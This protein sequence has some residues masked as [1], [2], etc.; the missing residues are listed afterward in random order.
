MALCALAA[1]ATPVERCVSQATESLRA[2]EGELKELEATLARGYAVETEIRT[3]PVFVTCGGYRT[4]VAP[5]PCVRDRVVRSPKR[6]PVDLAEVRRRAS[7]IRERLPA[8]QASA[9]QGA[10]QCRAAYAAAAGAA[11]A[12]P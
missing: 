3:Y 5:Y 9:D 8:L 4:G 12:T 11:P 1:C 2:A 7:D 10:A 6:V